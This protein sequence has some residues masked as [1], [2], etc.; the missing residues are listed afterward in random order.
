MKLIVAISFQL[1][2]TK[3]DMK[4][5]K[6]IPHMTL[7]FNIVFISVHQY[8]NILSTAKILNLQ[9]KISWGPPHCQISSQCKFGN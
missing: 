6:E 3:F 7:D 5:K 2:R 9:K 4:K 1:K 8:H